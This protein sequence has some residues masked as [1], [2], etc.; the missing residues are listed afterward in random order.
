[1]AQG[2]PVTSPE[3]QTHSWLAVST[4]NGDQGFVCTRCWLT[5]VS[6][7]VRESLNHCPY[8]PDA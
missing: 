6:L 7:P 8:R 3:P 1:M 5:A 4:R 2:K